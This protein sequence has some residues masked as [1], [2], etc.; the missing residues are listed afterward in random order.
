MSKEKGG[1]FLYD[2]GCYGIHSIRN[3]LGM[4][5]KSVYIH[6]ILDESYGV[7]TDVVGYL[8]FPQNV[9]AVF[10]ASF[11]MAK[12]AE[13][14]VAGTIGRILVPRAFLPDWYGGDKEIIV[15]KEGEKKI[16][17]VQGDQYREEVE[18]F[19]QTILDGISLSDLKHTFANSIGDMHVIDACFHSLL[20][21]K[22]VSI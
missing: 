13:Y 18:Y 12:R 4:E 10:D 17:Y 7:D 6:A 9:R 21:D 15:E 3:I 2:V 1:G 11:N 16:T 14:E 19:S 5:P 22:R 8:S 20:S